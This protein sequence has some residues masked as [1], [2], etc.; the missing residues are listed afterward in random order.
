MALWLA[1]R[2]HTVR[3]VT[4]PPYYPDWRVQNGYLPW[5]YRRESLNNVDVWRC[6]LWVPRNPSGITRI[7]HLLSFAF[8]SFPVML[9]QIFWK[10]D[11]V[12][13]I[14]PPLFCAPQA[15]I[16]AFLSGSKAWLHIQD[17]EIE[18]FFGLGFSSSGMLKRIAS[19]A[20]GWLMRRFDHVS[21]ISA[22][23][24]SRISRSG[25]KEDRIFFFPNW[26][27]V[28]HIRPH[29]NG[30]ALR[31]AWGIASDQK[32][33]L[34]SGSMGKKQGLE[35]IIEAASHFAETNSNIIFVLVG[36]GA[37]K[38]ELIAESEKRH[39]HNVVF[40]PLQPLELLPALLTMADIHL[41]IQ[42]RGIA[43]AVMPSKLT[44]ILAAGGFS[45]ITAEEQTELGQFVLRNPGIA[46]LVRPEDKGVLIQAISDMLAGRESSGRIN[47]AAR[48]H[49]ERYL[50]TD[51][52]MRNLEKRLLTAT[53]KN[54]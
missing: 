17:F 2:G 29:P 52:V 9:R 40:K 21:T 51:V 32:V 14:E 23:M 12:I 49:A 44:G 33:I 41:V 24:L 36:D 15:W 4:A 46:V 10:P 38:S 8:S 26:V 48:S 30:N 53:R 47:T 27:D 6:P 16:T 13:V 11:I 34:Y 37:A 43:D 50:A 3:V 28:G 54:Q 22:S 19:A 20:E 31:N 42:K 39:L 25:V 1:K 35:I 5:Q 7:I 18:A 45:L